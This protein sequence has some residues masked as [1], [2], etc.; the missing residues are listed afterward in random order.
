MAA[1]NVVVVGMYGMQLDS[2]RSP[3]RWEKWRPTVGIFQRDDVYVSTL[4]LIYQ[5]DKTPEPVLSDI[6]RLSPDT[7]VIPHALAFPRPWD[8]EDVFATLYDWSREQAFTEDAQD[9]WIHI[10]TGTHVMQICM[11][12]LTE[13]R[14]LPGRLLQT[15][16]PR[17]ERPPG[18]ELIDLNL[19]R[20]DRIARRFAETRAE[21]TSVL[22][23]GIATRNPG[24]NQMMEELAR[25]AEVSDAPILLSGPTGA[26]KS[27]LAR[28]I[29]EVKRRRSAS[30]LPL[31]EVNCATL[32][33]D[34]AMSTLFG[35][36]RGAFTGA[37]A[38]RTGVLA[39]ADGGVL[40]LDEI[41]ELG[42]DE[43]AMLLRALEERRFMPMGSDHET[44]SHFQLLAGTNRN[45]REDVRT[46][47]FREDLL[48]RIDLWHFELP[49]L[50]DRPEDIEPNL[51][52]ELEQ[53][54]QTSG[55]RVSFNRD[56]RKAF[57]TFAVSG[58]A[59]WRANFRD[60]NAAVV[61]MA[62]LA[63]G[64]RISELEVHREIA[65]LR[66]AWRGARGATPA[67]GLAERVLGPEAVAELDRFE[68]VQLD[69]VLDVC[70]KARTASDAGRVLF[71]VSRTRRKHTNDAD[72]LRKYLRRFG[73]EWAVIVERLNPDDAL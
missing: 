30:P 10:T 26:G 47:R 48:A 12:L 36:K 66:Q 14:F 27:R 35:H 3:R 57:L 43:Q 19:A 58:E 5:D 29:T 56:A 24:F 61:R 67:H 20:Y 65:R 22:K 6:A 64:G 63:P 40:F 52:F 28:A 41:G 15:S 68:R 18:V 13:A 71:A 4:H 62:T 25:V 23:S 39:S 8:F 33:G 44:E 7:T 53:F 49:G 73:L 17:Q 32:R 31:V 69:D 2:G 9:L 46:S 11:F 1:T 45:L 60:L 37:V 34:Q 54:A 38:D 59:A 21:G 55:R 51:D 72:R 42:L 70:R 16:P 50:R